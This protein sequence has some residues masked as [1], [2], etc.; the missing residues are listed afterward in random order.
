MNRCTVVLMTVGLAVTSLYSNAQRSAQDEPA[1]KDGFRRAGKFAGI[2]SQRIHLQRI[3]QA[4][5]WLEPGPYLQGDGHKTIGGGWSFGGDDYFQHA[6]GPAG[7]AN[8]CD[9]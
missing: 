9:C 8:L 6:E 1:R 5:V 7:D 2:A 4:Y 3:S